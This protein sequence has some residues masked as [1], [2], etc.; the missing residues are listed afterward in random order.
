MPMLAESAS[1]SASPTRCSLSDQ[2]IPPGGVPRALRHAA[3]GF[4]LDPIAE[5]YNEALK[6]ATEGHLKPARDRLQMLL[7]MCP[8][9]GDAALLLAKVYVAGQKWQEALAA[10]DA[11]SNA[12]TAVP[13]DL[14]ITTEEHNRADS[15]ADE[16]RRK[17]HLAREQGEIKALRQEA[18]RLRSENAQ[19]LGRTTELER[20]TQKWAWTTAG[21]SSLAILFLIV[22]LIF[23]GSSAP[24][25]TVAAVAPPPT[26]AAITGDPMVV[27]APAP[28]AGSAAP[29][30]AP[31][32]L[33]EKAAGVLASASELDGTTLEVEVDGSK[34]TL[35]GQVPTFRHRKTA[36]NL[37]QGVS[38]IETVAAGDVDITAR[39][40][41][42][43]HVVASGDNLSKIAYQYYGEASKA[44][45]VQ[46]ANKKTL[47]GRSNLSIGQ[48]LVIPAID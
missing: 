31:I 11:A 33:A 30:P 34:A 20:E 27:E 36:E 16:E 14:R 41:G 47:R 28:G 15:E 26:P 22:N 32:S 2:P 40:Q 42:S 25:T 12:G 3:E 39:S 37:L 45:V 35:T 29:A 46:K 7:T 5:L 44:G 10:M 21:V 19:L 48:E 9:D 8:E 13:D 23:G 6:Y 43:H 24:D 4:G 1:F 38:G 18:R 17:A